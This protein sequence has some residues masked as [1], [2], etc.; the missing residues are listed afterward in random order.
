MLLIPPTEEVG[1]EDHK[2]KVRLGKISNLYLKN[3]MQ[4]KRP[5]M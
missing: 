3:K 2:F 4:T 1:T 5:Q